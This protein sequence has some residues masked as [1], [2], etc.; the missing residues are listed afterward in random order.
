MYDINNLRG[1][2]QW[3]EPNCDQFNG[4][5]IELSP[6]MKTL[7]SKQ[8]LV[9][10]SLPYCLK[11]FN[12]KGVGNGWAEREV[13]GFL[14]SVHIRLKELGVALHSLLD[15]HGGCLPLNTV[16]NCFSALF[17]RQMD[18]TS[19]P[20]VSL[21]HLISCIAGVQVV[22]APGNGFK[23][24]RWS[25]KCLELAIPQETPPSDG[26]SEASDTQTKSLQNFSREVRDL[27]KHHPNSEVPFAK[28]VPAYH[29]HFGRQCCVHEFGFTKL[30]DL[31]EAI[32][33]VVQVLGK[34]KTLTLTHREQTKRFAADLLRV[35][36]GQPRKR[37]KLSDFPEAYE[38]IMKRPFSVTDYGVCFI[39]DIL[40]EVWEG[41]VAITFDPEDNGQV[42]EIPKRVQT[43]EEKKR[44]QTFSLEVQDLLRS[45]PS[46]SLPFSKFI[47]SYHHFY[48]RQCKV[49]RYG[50]VKLIELL[51]E[52]SPEVVEIERDLDV[53]EE[54][55][56]IRLS[57]EKRLKI[58]EQRIVDI[59]KYPA[60][61]KVTFAQLWHVYRSQFGHSLNFEDYGA[62]DLPEFILL[63]PHKLRITS[64]E[65]QEVVALVRKQCPPSL[66][67]PIE[68][69]KPRGDSDSSTSSDSRSFVT[70]RSSMSCSRSW[71][72]GANFD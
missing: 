7:P 46:L 30:V 66:F 19:T 18:T 61:R 31:M 72:M 70:N 55:K 9:T 41:T 50:F 37:V 20:R 5:Y 39:E 47:P 62:S 60:G 54:E 68:W 17:G 33:Q 71:R 53:Q 35:L 44:T 63:F 16:T 1:V 22:P 64:V 13:P 14:P 48:N 6:S 36:R 45:M 12:L 3:V 59:V 23:L 67:P 69:L 57:R 11:H 24:I 52:I 28:F 49:S 56:V 4:R 27:L 43:E 10:S 8:L 25:E 38:S 42:I 51:E 40:S 34:Q 26:T 2:V 32:P 65:G 58:I 29:A 15:I 21:E